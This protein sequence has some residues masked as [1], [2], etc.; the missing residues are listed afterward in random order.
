MAVDSAYATVDEYKTRVGAHSNDNDAQ[1]LA[2][3]NSASR[4]IDRSCSRFFTQDV[5]AVERIFDGPGGT[6]GDR[7]YR[8]MAI[9]PEYLL[10]GAS[11]SRFYLPTDIS[12][13]AGLVVKIDLD[14]DYVQE[15]TLTLNTHFWLAPLNAQVG[16]ELTPYTMMDIV[17]NNGVCSYIPSQRRVLSITAKWGWP[18][19]PG[20]IKEAT[21]MVARQIAEIEESGTVLT[22]QNMEAA[23]RL[24]P[25]V[26]SLVTEIQKLY[27]R[28]RKP[29]V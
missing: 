6:S 7:Y 20:P 15:Q 19:I 23:V 24:S 27:G 28:P 9:V 21:I 10:I 4:L 1:I 22:L 8:D 12:S 18:A 11:A 26:S 2:A 16:A 29:F 3:L 5:S 14:G 25:R 17:P 13:T